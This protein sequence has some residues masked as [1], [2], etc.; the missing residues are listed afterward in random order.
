MLHVPL[1][2]FLFGREQGFYCFPGF[3]FFPGKHSI[4]WKEIIKSRASG[5]FKLAILKDVLKCCL[6]NK[7][8]E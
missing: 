8:H 4:A 2:L 5:L 1:L 6:I 3:C 7:V